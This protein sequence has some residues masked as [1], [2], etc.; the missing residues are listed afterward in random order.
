MEAKVVERDLDG[1]TVNDVVRQQE[2]ALANSFVRLVALVWQARS[3]VD[4]LRHETVHVEDER[5]FAS[6]QR[7]DG[8]ITAQFFA[9]QLANVKTEVRGEGGPIIGRL[10]LKH[11]RFLV[12]GDLGSLERNGEEDASFE[13]LLLHPAVKLDFGIFSGEPLCL[14]DHVLKDLHCSFAVGD[15]LIHLMGLTQVHNINATLPHIRL[16]ERY[17]VP[18]DFARLEDHLLRMKAIVLQ[19]LVGY[20]VH[21]EKL[22]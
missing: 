14:S 3:H 18:D 10:H 8:E 19:M 22:N 13:C 20:E 7:L 9:K 16:V 6:L 21:H 1:E 15:H 11:A 17:D 2:D 4:L 5:W 12:L